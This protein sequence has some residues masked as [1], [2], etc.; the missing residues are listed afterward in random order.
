[1]G[2]LRQ[3]I[4]EIHRRSLWQVLLIYVGGS[5][6]CYELID[7]ISSRFALP[8]W[9]PALVVVLFLLGLPFVA[10]TAFVREEASP[11]VARAEATPPTRVEADVARRAARRRHRFLTARSAGLSFL[12]ALAVWGVVATGWIFLGGGAGAPA[13]GAKSVAVLPFANLSGDPDN[14]YFADGITDDVITHLSKVADLKVTSRTSSMRYKDTSQGLREIASQLGVATILEAGVQRVGDRIRVNAQLIDAAT[15]EHLWAEQYDRAIIDIFAIQTDIAQQIVAALEAT[16]TGAEEE[17]IARRP[18]DNLEAYDLY[19]QARFL[20]NRRTSQDL[21]RA[22]GLF[23][24]AI[25]LDSSY[26]YAYVGLADTYS[27]LYSWNWMSWEAAIPAADSALQRSLELDPALGEAHAARANILE[28]QRSWVRAD[29]GFVRALELAPGYATAHHWYA[30]MLAKLGRFEEAQ[31][32]IR[33]AAELDPLSRMISTNVGW[34]HHLARDYEAA[35]DQLET[36]VAGEPTFAYP[37][38]L[39]GE[40]YAE[41][42]RYSEAIATAQ[43]SV[44]LEPWPNIRLRLAYVYERAGQSAEAARIVGEL[45]G[46]GDPTRYA[47]WYVAAGDTELAFESLEQAFDVQSPFLNELKV[48]P[49]YDPVRSDPRF[50]EL[51]GR[52]ELE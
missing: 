20:W 43:R 14:E 2:R 44:E 1:M 22:I 7:T 49:G 37:W 47:L 23:E 25:A 38:A 3:I 18:T 48:E 46:I 6:A 30:L 42:G 11:A 21:Q 17:R 19:V 52:L 40:A 31:T 27:T 10:A 41:A 50:G 16:L 5:W 36:V 32:E 29:S 9:L 45:Q 35:I 39:L 15:D 12:S 33:R 13:T 51:L 34:V 28:A 4:L 26:A 24:E 8:E